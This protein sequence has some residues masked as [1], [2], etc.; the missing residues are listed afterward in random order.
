[1][2]RYIPSHEI[3]KKYV[4]MDLVEFFVSKLDKN[5]DICIF[6]Y[7]GDGRRIH[8]CMS[9][10]GI[11][12]NCICDNNSF[13]IGDRSIVSPALAVKENCQALFLVT[14]HLHSYEMELQLL[15]MGIPEENIIS[16]DASMEMAYRGMLPE[17]AYGEMVSAMQYEATGMYPDLDSPQTF[18]EKI[19][20]SMISTPLPI[21][22]ALADK[23]QVRSWVAEK[24]G[25]KYLIPLIGDW[26]KVEDIPWGQL[27]QKYAMK[28]NH[29]CGFNIVS[30]GRYNMD[31]GIAKRRLK[32]WFK[33]NF[34]FVS[35]ERQYISIEPH[36][37]CEQYIENIDGDV[38][39]YKIFCF[40]G[41][42]KYIMVLSQRKKGLR[43][44]FLDINWN[45]LP[46]VYTYPKS[47]EIPPKPRKLEEMIEVTKILCEDFDHVRVDWYVLNDGSI[48][49][50]EMTFT[51]AG[52]HAAW[53]PPEWDMKLGEMW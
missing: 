11:S 9:K 44:L 35:Y 22:T 33:C 37:I 27:P 49:F 12:V 34:G 41:E 23:Y 15:R 52:G 51:S 47:N 3:L 21:K 18:N 36:I 2:L 45:A 6:G 25:E 7:G 42:P 19:L 31:I 30:D 32:S 50:G 8:E 48:K 13:R 5:S 38:C 40:H 43:M 17:C 16:F 24:I 46:F 39:D 14:S 10:A 20:S 26:E 28:L 53:N 29:G 1:M 4:G